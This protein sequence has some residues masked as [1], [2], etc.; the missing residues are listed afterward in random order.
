MIG[1]PL[2]QRVALV[3]CT[4]TPTCDINNHIL[5]LWYDIRKTPSTQQNI[6]HKI[7]K[8]IQEYAPTVGFKSDLFSTQ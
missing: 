2:L 3:H 1:N 8:R 5:T 6:I 4:F 7:Y